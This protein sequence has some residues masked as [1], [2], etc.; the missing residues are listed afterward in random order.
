MFF[1]FFLLLLL[2]LFFFFFLT[3]CVAS[4]SLCSSVVVDS[5]LSFSFFSMY[6]TTISTKSVRKEHIQ[7]YATRE[8][9]LAFKDAPS[10]AFYYCCSC[11]LA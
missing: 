7:H 5:C 9:S 4:S 6:R 8:T 3:A 1:F 11:V 10:T 2:L